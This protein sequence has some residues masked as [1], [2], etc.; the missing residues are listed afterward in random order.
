MT[1]VS[2][3]DADE[4]AAG[5]KQAVELLCLARV[6]HRVRATPARGVPLGAGADDSAFKLLHLDVGLASISL[7]LDLRSLENAT[8]LTLVNRGAL[9][10][11]AVGQ[12][13]RLTFA[14]N[15]EPVLHWWRR[16]K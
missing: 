15:D 9:I 4:R 1:P 8:D 14:V 3:V 2:R 7:G 6:C 16:E 5:L 11:Q 10:E 12:L 13:L